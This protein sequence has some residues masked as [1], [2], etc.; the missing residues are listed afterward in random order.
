M[1]SVGLDFSNMTM[2]KVFGTQVKNVETGVKM[3]APAGGGGYYNEFYGVDVL[4]VGD[5]YHCSTLANDNKVFGGRIND[6]TNGTI[7]NDNTGNSYYSVAIEVFS[8]I[9]HTV[10]PSDASQYIRFVNSRLENS[11]VAGTGF[12]VSSN[13]QSVSIIAPQ[14]TSVSTRI[15]DSGSD[16][17]LLDGAYAMPAMRAYQIKMA[18][19]SLGNGVN[20]LLYATS[21]TGLLA[22]NSGDTDYM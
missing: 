14:F 13:A 12:N 3:T 4:T 19:E 2:C 7:D 18:D 16:T 9:G 8:N 15:V 10:S 21:T 1:R 22:R 6:C 11:S 5:G 17:M 20:V